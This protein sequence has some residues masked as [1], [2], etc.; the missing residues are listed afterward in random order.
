[1]S[2]ADKEAIICMANAFGKDESQLTK[3]KGYI[4]MYQDGMRSGLLMVEVE[5]MRSL[6]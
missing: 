2:Q 1:M 3:G 4:V 6:V 5:L